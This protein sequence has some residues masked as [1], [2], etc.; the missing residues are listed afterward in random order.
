[1]KF[2]KRKSNLTK[3]EEE[4]RSYILEEYARTLHFLDEHPVSY[5]NG[6][7]EYTDTDIVNCANELG[8]EAEA[9]KILGRIL[10]ILGG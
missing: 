7:K 8:R 4:I 9:R 2:F 3:R 1:M 5:A 6:I 10:D